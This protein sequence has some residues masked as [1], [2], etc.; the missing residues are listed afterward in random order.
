MRLFRTDCLCLQTETFSEDAFH[1]GEMVKVYV[2]GLQGEHPTV[3]KL[4][5][6]CKHTFGYLFRRY[7]YH[8]SA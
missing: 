4:S 8:Y 2:S 6:T 7:V 3:R 5:A 1:T